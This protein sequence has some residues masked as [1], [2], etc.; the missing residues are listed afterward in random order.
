MRRL[1][2]LATALVLTGLPV[3]AAPATRSAATL[4]PV[5]TVVS[6]SVLKQE[7][8]VPSATKAAYK[9]KY[10]TTDPFGHRSYSTGEVFLP[11]GK[12]PKG[13]WPV[14]SWA[15][16]TSGLADACAPSR[17]GPALK[18]RDFYYLRQWLKQGYAIVA[19]D[20]V[21]LGTPG[22]MPYLDGRTTAHSVVD[23]VKAGRRFAAAHL[24]ANSQLAKKWVVIGQSQGGG[25]AIYTARYAT[26]FG[27]AGLDYRGAV[28]T[29]TPAY[30]ENY[31]LPLGPGTPPVP[32]TPG[33]TEYM[34]YIIAGLRYVHPE[35]GID[36]ILTDEGKRI[37]HIAE[38]VCSNEMEPLVADSAIGDWFTAPL[39]TL[40]NFA[41]VTRDYLGM[42]ETGYDKPFFM[43][44]G[45]LDTDVPMAATAAY[46]GVLTANQQPVEFH[47][48]PTGDH[49]TT[50]KLSLPDSIPFVAKQF[51]APAPSSGRTSALTGTFTTSDAFVTVKDGPANAHTTKLDIR[52]YRPANATAAHPKPAILVAHGFGGTKDSGEVVNTARFFA[53]HGYAVLT[54]TAQGFGMSSGCI[55]LDSRTYDV[56]DDRQLISKVLGPKRWVRHDRKGVVVGTAGGSYGGGIQLNLAEADP[57]IRAIAPAR[58]W[59]SLQYALDPNNWVAPGDPTGFTHTLPPQG[60]FKREWTTEFF[61]K[62]AAEPVL[63]QQGACP[64]DK[65]AP[66]I[67]PGV[68]CT[69]YWPQ[70]CETF[71]R[72][73]ATGDANDVDKALVADSSGSTQISKLRVPTL[74]TQGQSDTLFNLNDAVATYTT[75]RRNHV[76]VKMIWNAGGHG[77][78]ES[79][80]GE[81]ELN[82]A[83]GGSSDQNVL[84]HCYLPLRQLAFFDHW[85]KGRPDPSP[86]FTFFCDWVKYD[87]SGPT[88]AYGSAPAFPIPD[89]TTYT[90]SG[91]DALTTGTGMPGSTQILNPTGGTPAAYTE[92]SSFTGP[93]T[94]PQVPLPPSD[95]PG[96]F[97]SFDSA[98]FAKPVV[99]V[100]VPSL[101]L[102]LS[103]VAPTDL[104]LFAKV[105]DVA[106]DGSATLIHRLIAPARIPSSA[107]DA[108]VRIKLL[109]F[110]HRFAAGHSVRL[111]LC[112]TDATSSNNLVADVITIGTGPGSTFSLP[113]R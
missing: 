18:A 12:M 100:G 9:L 82:D 36:A 7:L 105:W 41:A 63:N 20:Y 83:N 2:L 1:L 106:P 112:T 57:R 61:A 40:P 45:T 21:G 56:K 89:G 108:P 33:I 74:L 64:R 49:N 111:T 17:I 8:W 15:H 113:T 58:T 95:I 23:M 91:S 25:A 104:H 19:S 94:S 107:L 13:G 110:V 39:A 98:P 50:L 11:F 26:A 29:G 102:T 37:Q 24:P 72:L 28:G 67:A 6:H 65:T 90:L 48:Y 84:D 109:G 78:Y 93:N 80:P 30:I 38:T 14:I 42:P 66:D 101:R 88:N 60:L 103:H 54:Y 55:S 31:L 27:G 51:Q 46:V 62:G 4:P 99:S 47:T 32:L 70:L 68:A 10:V 3:A 97:A 73:S 71:A 76:P 75:L 86:G 69:G 5:G 16:G 43:G 81:C 53:R 87:G 44:H 79:A 34:A 52:L 92:T 22:L 59:N 85:L 77:G 96:Q 35:L